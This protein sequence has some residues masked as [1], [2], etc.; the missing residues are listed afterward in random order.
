MKRFERI[1]VE[2]EKYVNPRLCTDARTG[3]F[4]RRRVG[5]LCICGN[6]PNAGIHQVDNH[7]LLCSNG[8]SGRK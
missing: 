5:I 8:Y 1:M 6:S 4:D 7:A 3:V 2:K